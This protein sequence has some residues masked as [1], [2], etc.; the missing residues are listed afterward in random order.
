MQSASAKTIGA[1]IEELIGNLGIKQK[2]REYD[3][4][5]Y[6]ATAV[7]AQIAKVTSASRITDGVLTVN[8]KTSTWRNELV[9]R[10]KEIIEKV[11]GAIGS[12]IVKDIKFQ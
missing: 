7:G 12:E 11:N 2:L 6:W 1:A 8:V 3:A 4:I 9:L 10:K 5:L